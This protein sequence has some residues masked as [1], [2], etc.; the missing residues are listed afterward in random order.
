MPIFH[1]DNEN[2]LYL[3]IRLAFFACQSFK[4]EKSPNF[5]SISLPAAKRVVKVLHK[6]ISLPAAKRRN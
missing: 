1:A 6:S 5:E 3:A 2:Q 4:V